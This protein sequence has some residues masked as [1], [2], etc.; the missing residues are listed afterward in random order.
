MQTPLERQL[1]VGR[2]GMSVR[3]VGAVESNRNLH[4]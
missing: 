1:D 2:E 3:L 4:E